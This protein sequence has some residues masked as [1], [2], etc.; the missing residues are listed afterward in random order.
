VALRVAK[1]GAFGPF[2]HPYTPARFTLGVFLVPL[3]GQFLEGGFSEVRQE[4]S[5]KVQSHLALALCKLGENRLD[6]EPV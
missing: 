5:K 6:L 3:F 2:R 4:S 1:E